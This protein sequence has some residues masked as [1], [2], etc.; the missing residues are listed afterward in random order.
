V[1]VDEGDPMRVLISRLIAGGGARHQAIPMGYLG[2]LTQAFSRSAGDP[3]GTPAKPALGAV[4]GLSERELEVLVLLAAGKQNQ[5]IANELF[6][7][8]STVKK[9]VTH[10][11]SKLGAVNRTEATARARALG[12]LN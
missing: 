7:A 8:L 4:A 5:E 1:F 2:R 9:H 3:G 10:I 12:L 11:L 6:V